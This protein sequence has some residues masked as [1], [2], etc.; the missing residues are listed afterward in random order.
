LLISILREE[1]EG[2]REREREREGGGGERDREGGREGG[3]R[4]NARTHWLMATHSMLSWV[5]FSQLELQS[6]YWPA[7]WPQ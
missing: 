2:E 3:R 5:S 4:E 1:W 6:C 7:L